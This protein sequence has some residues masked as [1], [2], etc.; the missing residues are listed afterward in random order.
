MSSS[1]L[2]S[3]T[4]I[5]YPSIV[6][7]ILETQHRFIH[8]HRDKINPNNSLSFNSQVVAPDQPFHSLLFLKDIFKNLVDEVILR[9]FGHIVGCRAQKRERRDGKECCEKHKV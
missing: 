4:G 5:L 8:S 7:N 3:Y 1:F 9:R 2:N 6:T